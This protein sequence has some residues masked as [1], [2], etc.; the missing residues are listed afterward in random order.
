VVEESDAFFDELSQ[1]K[2]VQ[3]IAAELAPFPYAD[4]TTSL[5]ALSRQDVTL[6]VLDGVTDPHNLGALAR[7][8]AF[9]GAW[10]ILLPKDRS[11]EVT[12]T[13]ERVSAGAING[14]EVFQV[15]NLSRA[16]QELKAAGF[17]VYGTVVEGGV[18][19][20]A[21]DLRGRS[22]IVLGSEGHGMR[23]LTKEGCDGWITLPTANPVGSLNVSTFGA[24]ML[25][26]IWRQSAPKTT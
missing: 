6:L 20:A 21:V 4:L 23:R 9:F 24:V 22:A 5:Q 8:A 19:P 7:T 14:L 11:V 16:L 10:G 25:Y 2:S 3:G 18:P 1:G 13:V 17:W 12:P 15:T 26:E